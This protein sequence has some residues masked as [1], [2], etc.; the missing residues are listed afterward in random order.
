M[1]NRHD[2]NNGLLDEDPALDYILHQEM[3][4]EESPKGKIGCL[5]MA[6]IVLLP[7]GYGLL[8][9][10]VICPLTALF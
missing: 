8:H 3:G 2:D 6:F 7:I 4:Q 5:G 10:I 1:S 9:F